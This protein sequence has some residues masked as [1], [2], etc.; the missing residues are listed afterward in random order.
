[1]R[2][3][4][5]VLLLTLALLVAPS[6]TV[7]AQDNGGNI[8]V[9]S[10]YLTDSDGDNYGIVFSLSSSVDEVTCVYPYVTAQD[11]VNGGIGSPF[12]LEPNET[13]VRIGQFNRA[14][15]NRGWSVYVSAKW[16]AGSC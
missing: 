13:Y 7:F 5:T 15:S 10:Q 3:I 11:N 1:M 4:I 9:S 8:T 16:H 14:D 6:A 12:Q 2:N